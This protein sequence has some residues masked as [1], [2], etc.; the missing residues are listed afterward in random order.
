MEG[1]TLLKNAIPVGSIRVV[2][3]VN[4][5]KEERNPCSRE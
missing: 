3:R 4:S 5:E 1:T 2:H